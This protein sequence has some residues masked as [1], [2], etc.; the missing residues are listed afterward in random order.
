MKMTQE[1]ACMDG[2]MNDFQSWCRHI[3]R[4]IP[5]DTIGVSLN[6]QKLMYNILVPSII[7]P[8]KFFYGFMEDLEIFICP[9]RVKQVGNEN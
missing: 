3:Q 2:I 4:I 5:L 8:Y 1:Y 7:A 9:W 6:K